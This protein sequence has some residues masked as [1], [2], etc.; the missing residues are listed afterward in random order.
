MVMDIF[1]DF[2][3]YKYLIVNLLQKMKTQNPNKIE[4]FKNLNSI[5]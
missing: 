4:R 3:L 5:R 1:L 2:N